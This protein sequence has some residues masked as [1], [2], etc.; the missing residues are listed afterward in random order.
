MEYHKILSRGN[1]V[2]TRKNFKVLK[3]AL[4]RVALDNM[5]HGNIIQKIW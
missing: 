2:S 3:E 1:T 4:Y 5:I